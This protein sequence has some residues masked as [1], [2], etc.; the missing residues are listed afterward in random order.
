MKNFFLFLI[1]FFLTFEAVAQTA[2][3]TATITPT[4]T[5]TV[6]PTP[7]AGYSLSSYPYISVGGGGL[8]CNRIKLGQ[9]RLFCVDAYN[10][11][12][13]SNFIKFYNE[14]AIPVGGTDTV[15]YI[16][17]IP[18]LETRSFC[19]DFEASKIFTDGMGFCLTAVKD[20]NDTTPVG[21][22]EIT[23]TISYK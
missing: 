17:E 19:F 1:A 12:A 4:A 11:A 5:P 2:T 7:L 22:G 23:L 21:A 6:T 14:T 15:V 16:K 20:F 8:D 9:S 13:T 18:G 10:N 3:P